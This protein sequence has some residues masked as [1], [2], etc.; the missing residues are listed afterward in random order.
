M[1]NLSVLSR[2][3]SI[4]KS[5]FKLDSFLKSIL[6]LLHDELTTDLPISNNRRSTFILSKAGQSIVTETSCICVDLA[7]IT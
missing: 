1:A 7:R 4:V 3:E 6:Q 2:T 5:K